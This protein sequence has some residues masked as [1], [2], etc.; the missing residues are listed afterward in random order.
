MRCNYDHSNHERH[1]MHTRICA[2]QYNFSVLHLDF[3]IHLW[4]CANREIT[5]LAGGI[6]R[7]V[8]RGHGLGGRGTALRAALPCAV[9][10][11]HGGGAP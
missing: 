9:R 4:D 5:L 1:I 8:R 3:F 11:A 2:K 7:G 10:G 6:G